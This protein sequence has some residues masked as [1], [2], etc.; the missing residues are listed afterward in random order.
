MKSIA[1]IAT[2][3][4]RKESL[5]LML[6]SIEGQFDEVI[7]ID[8]GESKIDR[9]D[10]AKFVP[11]DYITEPCYIHL[12]DDDILYPSNYREHSEQMVDLYGI[13]TYHGRQLLGYG[14]EYFKGHKWYRC[15]DNV[16]Y[17]CI[18]DV[19]GTGVT[20]FRTDYFHPK[21]LADLSDKGMADIV[22]SLEAAKQKK[23]ITLLNHKAGWIKPIHNEETLYKTERRRGAK[24]QVELAD[25]IFKLNHDSE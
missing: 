15:F 16:P 9:K 4:P 12:L 1:C 24:R 25:E 5:K 3:P 18:V 7:V 6:K 10:N 19:C 20:S 22:F 2:Y 8:N 21:G 13:V 11:L 17:D 23:V 14:R